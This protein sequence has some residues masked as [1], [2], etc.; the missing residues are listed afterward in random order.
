MLRRLEADPALENDERASR[1]H[2]NIASRDAIAQEIDAEEFLQ[3]LLERNP[4]NKMAFELLMAH[5][6]C[7]GRPEEVVANLSRLKDFSYP[8]VPR[9]FQEALAVHSLSSDRPLPDAGLELDPEVLRRFEDFQRI[10]SGA[11]GPEEAL[12]GVLEAGL[13]DSYF[14]YLASG[15]SGG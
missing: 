3:I 12:R 4:H 13:E 15:V 8:R 9:Y 1:I 7:D 10:M 14:F 11:R 2:A 6:L 5:Y